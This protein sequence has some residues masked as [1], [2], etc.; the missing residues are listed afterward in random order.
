[1]NEGETNNKQVRKVYIE[2]IRQKR[3]IGNTR[4]HSITFK[5]EQSKKVSL[6]S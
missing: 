6:K 1:M 5:M 4:S 2:K 3:E